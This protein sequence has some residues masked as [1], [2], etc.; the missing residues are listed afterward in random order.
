ME[1]HFCAIPRWNRASLESAYYLLKRIESYCASSANREI[2]GLA[3]SP[4]QCLSDEADVKIGHSTSIDGQQSP[5]HLKDECDA[6]LS[7]RVWN[8]VELL[9]D[10][11]R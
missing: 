3:R 9:V 11:L 8:A 6:Q 10:V 4:S 7:R 5:L 2:S 1:S